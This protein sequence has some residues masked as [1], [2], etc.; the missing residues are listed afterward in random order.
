ESPAVAAPIGAVGEEG[1]KAEG[2]APPPKAARAPAAQP[3]PPPKQAAPAAA[4]KPAAPPAVPTPRPQVGPAQVVPIRREEEAP[5]E[6]GRLRASPVAKRIAEERGLDLDAV[7]GAGAQGRI[8][9]LDIEPALP[10]GAAG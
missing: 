10:P 2:R 6:E 7:Q 9:K 5:S 4:A 8:I 1:E 3:V